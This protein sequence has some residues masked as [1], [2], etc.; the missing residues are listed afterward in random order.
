MTVTGLLLLTFIGCTISVSCAPTPTSANSKRHEFPDDFIFGAASSAYQYE[1]AWDEDGKGPSIWD[2]FTAKY[3]GISLSLSTHIRTHMNVIKCTHIDACVRVCVCICRESERWK[4]GGECLPWLQDGRAS[5]SELNA[6]GVKYYKN[7]INELLSNGLKPFATIFFWDLPQ[8]L[9]NDEGFLNETI[10]DEFVGYANICFAMFGDRVKHWITINEPWS[11]SVFGY[12]YGTFPPNRCSKGRNRL[13]GAFSSTARFSRY[14]VNS[15]CEVGDSGTEPYRVAHHLILAHSAA[16]QLYR[17]K[18]R[19]DHGG[20]IGISL[21][22]EWMITYDET[23]EK[24]Q[25]A[26]DRALAFMYGWYMEPLKS[27]TYPSQM[28]THVE[29]RLP[30]FTEEQ[31]QLVKGSFE[32]IG[33]NYYTGAYA[34]DI[35]CSNN[36]TKNHSYL[37]Y[38]CVRLT[39]VKNG[40]PIGNETGSGWL[41][42]YPQ[43]IR[44][45]LIYTKL[46]Y[47]DPVVY[48]TENGK[49]E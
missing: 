9:E 25:E 36:G 30:K 43:G 6:A 42:V 37:R 4:D 16:V 26:A 10:V 45:T 12:A 15:D 18:Y 35:P 38:S 14:L 28:V 47:N 48:I 1:G 27:G 13:T 22:T 5:S 32:F 21:N 23:S 40:I 31:S 8:A 19:A 24:D 2:T 41:Y 44:D 46:W 39:K 7:L 17:E 33:L 34:A 11:Y 49:H 20:Q 29:D 3:P